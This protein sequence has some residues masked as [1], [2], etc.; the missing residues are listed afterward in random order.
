MQK[1]TLKRVAKAKALIARGMP[2]VRAIKKAKL[3][4]TTYNKYEKTVTAEVTAKPNKKVP[5]EFVDL[6]ATGP[7]DVGSIVVVVCKPDQ[8]RSVIGGI[9]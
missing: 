9:Q 2:K 1:A 5:A 8:L 7:V 6:V 4:W 3:N